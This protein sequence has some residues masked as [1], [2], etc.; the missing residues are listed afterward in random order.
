ML[1]TFSSF[2]S[3]NDDYTVSRYVQVGEYIVKL[4]HFSDFINYFLIVFLITWLIETLATNQNFLEISLSK[5]KDLISTAIKY[6]SKIQS[7]E[8]IKKHGIIF[9]IE[10][11]GY[12]GILENS[13]K[14]KYIDKLLFTNYKTRFKIL[15]KL[16]KKEGILIPVHT[17]GDFRQI[18]N[19]IFEGMPVSLREETF[20]S[21]DC[22]IL[23]VF[24]FHVM[25]QFT[26]LKEGKSTETVC[27]LPFDH[28]CILYNLQ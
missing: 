26:S 18:R 20:Y 17:F 28:P 12:L 15:S 21:V 23:K 27:Y 16:S 25:L 22:K 1:Q 8:S 24:K 6:N 10:N 3:I 11:L 5:N 19:F 14:N 2:L 13:Q 7:I 9:S 4:F